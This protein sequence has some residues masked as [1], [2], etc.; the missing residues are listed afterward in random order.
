MGLNPIAGLVGGGVGGGMGFELGG[1]TSWVNPGISDISRRICVGA[2]VPE[3][4]DA[5]AAP[6]VVA[7][8]P[9][10]AEAF[11]PELVV[12]PD[13]RVV[14]DRPSGEVTATLELEAVDDLVIDCESGRTVEVVGDRV[15]E[16]GIGAS[17]VAVTWFWRSVGRRIK[18][19]GFLVVVAEPFFNSTFP[20]LRTPRDFCWGLLCWSVADVPIS[21]A[22]ANTGHVIGTISPKITNSITIPVEVE[23]NRNV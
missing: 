9:T 5:A 3:P 18:R 7:V 10:N 11:V 19:C 14:A 17:T 20:S 13:W 6:L 8:D 21:S 2:C 23:R 22:T 12:T 16:V 15:G 4:V 1:V